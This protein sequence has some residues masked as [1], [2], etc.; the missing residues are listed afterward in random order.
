MTLPTNPPSQAAKD[1]A[2]QLIDHGRDNCDH[3]YTDPNYDAAAT[4]IQAALTAY[5][6]SKLEEAALIVENAI[7][8][9]WR[10]VAALI[11]AL[12]ERTE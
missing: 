10:S 2:K 1:L 11:R 12:K 7:F 4:L 9:K 8:S 6:N 3:I 5:G